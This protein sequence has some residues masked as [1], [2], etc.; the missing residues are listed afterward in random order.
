MSATG[1]DK[2]R[3]EHLTWQEFD[4]RVKDNYIFLLVAGAIEEHG[5][6]LPL[7]FDAM[8]GTEIALEL[9]NRYR[10]VV[11][12][13]LMYGY[14]SQAL[15]GGGDLFPGTTCVG[16]EALIYT[17]RD[18]LQEMFRH[19]VRRIVVMNSHLENQSFLVEG[20]ELARRSCDLEAS[21]SKILLT[22]WASF[23]KDETLDELFDGNFPGWD[24]EH[25]ALLE[26]SAMLGIR[27]EVVDTD[28]LPDEQP[29]RYPKYSVFP[30]P[31]DIV[32]VNGALAPAIG[33]SREKGL[34][35]LADVF[36][37]FA[38]AFAF[39]FELDRQGVNA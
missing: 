17:V 10:A 26:T 34:R 18:L 25:A 23:V 31:R 32:T 20:I 39:E 4:R 13:T 8:M 3:V 30:T 7:G 36:E 15:I 6:H 22:S 16:A 11:M 28:A 33:A 14:R 1:L 12:P 21:G 29:P 5:P 37:G 19:G 2:R 27:P 35:I 9:A 38:E 24:P